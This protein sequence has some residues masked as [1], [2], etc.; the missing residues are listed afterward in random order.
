M[1]DVI[2]GPRKPPDDSRHSAA[3][4]DT[5]QIRFPGGHAK[6]GNGCQPDLAK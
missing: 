5:A 3:A 6:H 4:I 2:D 1:V